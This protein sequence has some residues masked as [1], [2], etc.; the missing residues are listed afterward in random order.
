MVNRFRP[1]NEVCRKGFAATYLWHEL[2]VEMTGYHRGIYLMRFRG[3]HSNRFGTV[4]VFVWKW[5]KTA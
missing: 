1:Y 4:P 2:I 3:S 5:R